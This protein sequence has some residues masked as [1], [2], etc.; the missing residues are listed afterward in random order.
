MFVLWHS[1][2]K[3][4]LPSCSTLRRVLLQ[5]LAECGRAY[6]AY[7]R[8]LREHYRA[9]FAAHPREA[10]P[11]PLLA[12]SRRA[13][14]AAGWEKLADGVLDERAWHRWHRSGR[15]SQVI[16]VGLWVRAR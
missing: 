4:E 15:S 13:A 8:E 9:Y 14:F 10:G 2:G 5:A 16:T 3:C 11:H 12:R 6:R 7:E 1:A